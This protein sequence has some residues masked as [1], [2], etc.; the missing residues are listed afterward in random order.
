MSRP[1]IVTFVSVLIVSL[2]GCTEQVEPTSNQPAGSNNPA[3]NTAPQPEITAEPLNAW[4]DTKYEALVQMS[5]MTLTHL[6]RKDRYSEFDDMSETAMKSKFEWWEQSV[7]E[8]QERFDY[9]L[10]TGEEQISYD[11]FMQ[12]FKHAQY[13]Y[14]F[15]KQHY[16]FTQMVGIH[17]GLPN[18]LINS[19]SVSSLSDMQAYV[20]RIGGLSAAIT[21]LLERAKNN[22][23]FGV[24][25][26]YF[27]YDEVIIQSRSLITGYPFTDDE[28][29]SPLYADAKSKIMSLVET[30]VITV[31][32]GDELL[33]SSEQMLLNQ[34]KPSYDDLINWLQE[35]R[36]NASDPAKGVSELPDGE[37]FYQAKLNMSTT[38][39]MNA[40]EIHQ[41]GLAEIKRL[42]IE[43]EAIK[44]TVGF[45][46]SLQE[47]FT[48][49]KQDTSNE[50]F[51]YPDTDAGREAYLQDSRDYLALLEKE[52]PAYFGLLPKSALIVKRVEAFRE[53]PGMAQHYNSGSPDGTR[54][55]TYY[56]HL[57]DMTAMP[58][59][60]ME[61]VAYHEGH[62]GHHMQISIAQELE[63]VPIFRTQAGFTAFVEGWGVYS[64]VLAKEMGFYQDPYSDF[65]RLVLEIWRAI[66]LV[67]DTGINAKGW[68]EQQAIAFFQENSPRSRHSIKSEVRRYFVW[69]GQAT[70][71]KVGQLKI[72]SLR[73]E[74]K[75]ILGDKFDIRAFHDIVLGGGSVPLSIVERR[76][77]QWI[78][79]TAAANVAQC[80]HECTPK[81]AHVG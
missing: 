15:R 12:Q 68:S 77:A 71:Y 66:R 55:G 41:L 74:A 7:N 36:I 22:A 35:D 49:V 45:K 48:F 18:F 52:L 76:I 53:Q 23:E 69:P 8:L 43:M 75:E 19:H 70:A 14:E 39:D 9:D 16:V 25:P 61:A 67:L 38:T 80:L 29:A 32:E 47:F 57:S 24:R 28:K 13:G 26:P 27:S 40:E 30:D 21:Q 33:A 34:F 42:R 10:L 72:L 31:E 78:K 1:L 20:T 60:E 37:R 5:P 54:L 79:E 59:I 64:E 4:F 17:V 65:G 81:P 46:G 58:K 56:A 11:I 63:N 3:E 50:Q 44:A 6:G 2:L 73:H 62:P 51:F